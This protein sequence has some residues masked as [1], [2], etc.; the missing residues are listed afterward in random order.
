M[1]QPAAAMKE[2]VALSAPDLKSAGFRKRRYSFNRDAADGL[3]H[4]VL[5]C[6]APKEPP[7]WTEVP[8]LRERTYG[9]FRIDTGVYVPEMNRSGSPRSSWVNEYNCQ[10]RFTVGQL[11]S[12]DRRSNLWWSL[13]D[14]ESPSSARTALTEV[15]LPWLDKFPDRESVV[16]AFERGGPLPMGMSPA[17]GLD[18]ADVLFQSGDNARARSVLE[19]YVAR[20]VLTSHARYLAGYLDE[21]GQSDLVP[22]ISTRS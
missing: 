4:V 2:V 6:M 8:G 14:P 20:P 19:D 7:A 5:F 17:G 12:G 3:V 1:T 16:S 18:I 15:V 13:D 9:N 21:R 10:L 22:R 11:L